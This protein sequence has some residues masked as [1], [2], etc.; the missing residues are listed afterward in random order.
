M[1]KSRR[2]TRKNTP[3]TRAKNAVRGSREP[4]STLAKTLG[5]ATPQNKI[6]L[7]QWAE[8]VRFGNR[9]PMRNPFPE[10]VP[11]IRR[12]PKDE[13]PNFLDEVRLL[14]TRV[15]LH[16]ERMGLF[17]RARIEIDLAILRS[18]FQAAQ[19]QIDLIESNLGRSLW[20]LKLSIALAALRD[21][22]EAQKNLTE[23]LIGARQ[24]STTA[25]VLRFTSQRNEDATSGVRYLSRLKNV[26]ERRNIQESLKVHYNFHLGYQVPEAEERQTWLLIHQSQVS[27]ID[28]YEALISCILAV[29]TTKPGKLP[30]ELI[31][32]LDALSTLQDPRIDKI[33]FLYGNPDGGRLQTRDLTY[34]QLLIKGR[35]P[36]QLDIPNRTDSRAFWI[37]A[38]LRVRS[39]LD[40]PLCQCDLRH[41]PSIVYSPR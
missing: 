6:H 8:H 11:E 26:L 39:G 17:I 37:E 15:L 14:T 10:Q 3:L 23:E 27:L 16:A 38:L 30:Q 35:K 32:A 36:P 21:G 41:L 18:D 29:E 28:A 31:A 40:S 12:L 33:H 19:R 24:K 1:P 2:R 34:D 25:S 4:A 13:T 22:L 7:L 9:V 5:T 20:L